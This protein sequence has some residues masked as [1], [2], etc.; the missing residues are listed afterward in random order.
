MCWSKRCFVAIPSSSSVKHAI[1]AH[2]VSRVKIR[3]FFYLS[4]LIT[5]QT[6][7][8]TS[9][10]VAHRFTKPLHSKIEKHSVYSVWVI[11]VLW[12]MRFYLLAILLVERLTNGFLLVKSTNGMRSM[13]CI[14]MSFT[15]YM[16]SAYIHKP[17]TKTCSNC[18]TSACKI[19][20]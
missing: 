14:F 8:F 10:S 19:I 18:L 15:V 7:L 17:N 12:N 16:H 1:Y 4:S 3:F 9:F 5:S 11:F 6:S 2:Y 13:S 20:Q